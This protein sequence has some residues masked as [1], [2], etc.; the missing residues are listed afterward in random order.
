METENAQRS[1]FCPSSYI[2]R[3][4][5]K[6]S[7]VMSL[8]FFIQNEIILS[9]Y[10]SSEMTAGENYLLKIHLYHIIDSYL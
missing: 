8:Y 3:K 10:N 7:P 2:I 5:I 6:G 4:E 9:H 1:Y